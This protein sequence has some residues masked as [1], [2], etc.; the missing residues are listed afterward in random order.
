MNNERAFTLVELIVVITILAI[1]WTIA[2]ISL[3]W[4][5]ANAR[6]S[7]RISNITNM[8]KSLA[9]RVAKDW[10]LPDPE[11]NTTQIT[12]SGA[13]I[14]TQWEMT[15]SMVEQ[16]LKMSWDITDP[17]DGTNPIYTVSV[18]KKNYQI[19]LF[20]EAE[21]L[22]IN[23][24]LVS[25]SYAADWKTFMTKWD[26]LWII[27]TDTETP[28]NQTLI[29]SIDISQTTT[30]Y[31]AYLSDTEVIEWPWEALMAMNPRSSCRRI[32]ETG[33]A[34]SWDNADG[35]YTVDFNWTEIQT[36]CNMTWDPSQSFLPEIRDWSLEDPNGLNWSSEYKSTEDSYSW[37]TAL[38]F[39]GWSW[40][41]V[42]SDYI[43]ID[44]TKTYTIEWYL[45][46]AWSV[47]SKVFFWFAEYDENFQFIA[48]YHVHAYPWTDAIL[49]NNVSTSDTVINFSDS[50]GVCDRW[51]WAHYFSNH[52]R[53]AFDVD[54]SGQYSD[55]P[56][57]NLSSSWFSSIVD[58]GDSCT[59]TLKSAVWKSYSAGTKIR[60]HQSGS[61]YNYSASN[62]I[63][64][65]ST[66]THYDWTVSWHS[67]Y[68][69]P[70]SQ[71][72][73]WTKFVKVYF[74]ANYLQDSSSTVFIDDFKL[75]EY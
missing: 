6:D 14:M 70:F 36:Y 16:Y 12:S 13:L 47:S 19:A 66:W 53:M 63:I 29:P 46:S 68:G 54:H 1:L 39:V 35:I 73:K 33:W 52:A 59:I 57:R 10:V 45:K 75:T 67:S 50:W 71:F 24:D 4:Y 41:K 26:K 37:S 28:V 5:T 2:L 60:M 20:L 15:Q 31:K 32:S 69:A 34:R 64:I 17:V 38:K 44:P 11:W 48:N 18:D 40:W 27:L 74:Y 61:S 42:S 65:P 55:L 58:N 43:Y 25:N 51:Q 3:E 30:T 9:L 49:L 23:N 62:W 56:N 8:D 7:V 22:A 21:N 72:R